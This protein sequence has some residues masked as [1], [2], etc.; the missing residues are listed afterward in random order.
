[1][2][3]STEIEWT[4]ATWNPLRG[5]ARVSNGCQHCYA[6]TVA[7]RFGG[8]G[9]PYEGLTRIVNGRPA[10]TGEVRL[11]PE[12][13][14]QPLRWRRPRRIFVNSMSDLFHESVPDAFISRVFSVMARAQHHTFQI[15]TKR[16]RRMRDVVSRL[17]ELDVLIPDRERPFGCDI[18]PR[19]N[20]WLGVSVENQAAADERIP[21]LLDTPAE[22][23]WI[24]AE[25]LLGNI[26]LTMLAYYPCPNAADGMLMDWETGAYECCT[27]CDH[28][29]ISNE[30]GIDWVVAGGE[31]GPDARP[32]HPDWLRSLRDQCADAGVPFFFKQWGEWS[33]ID[34]W[35]NPGVMQAAIRADGSKMPDDEWH[36]DGQRFLRIGKRVAGRSLD[37]RL[38]DAYPNCAEA[39]K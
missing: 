11:V 3:D 31:S 17:S 14:D 29:G 9:Q 32:M 35:R 25:P 19:E 34:C 37:G 12:M 27:D 38:H 23:R 26:D 39:R 2:S 1:M 4:D 18:R 30:I 24:S 36:E 22:V 5:C 33:P 10:W 13:L 15:L 6:E 16:A 21:L 28:T 7:H 8:P 20:V